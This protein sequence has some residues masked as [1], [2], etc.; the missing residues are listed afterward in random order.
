MIGT[1]RARVSY[2]MNKFRKLGF[3]AYNRTL[4][5]HSSLL[6]MVLLDNPEINTGDE[7]IGAKLISC[8]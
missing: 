4:E 2:F 8:R 6:N 1:T 3:I 7:A 5:V